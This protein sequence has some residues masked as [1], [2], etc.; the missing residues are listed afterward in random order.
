MEREMADRLWARALPWEL[1]LTGIV[2]GLLV[3][4]AP[5]V[6]LISGLGALGVVVGSLH[7][8]LIGI[9]AA[10]VVGPFRAWLEI[11]APGL[12]PHV[13]QAVLLVAVGAW[14]VQK[15]L[16]TRP[17]G[18][19]KPQRSSAFVSLAPL[20]AFVG[21]GLLSLWDPVDAWTGFLEWVKWAQVLLVAVVVLDRLRATGARGV[22]LALA[23]LGAS[24]GVQALVGI[25]QF[26]L[27]GTGVQ[28][29]AIDDRFYRAYGTFQQPNPYAGMLGLVGALAVGLAAA[30]L[31]DRW[32]EAGPDAPS[33]RR[34]FTRAPFGSAWAVAPAV[35]IVAGLGVSWSRGGWMG[36]GAAG[37]VMIVFLPRR[38][39]WGFLLLGGAVVLITALAATGR[40][41]ASIVERL[42][43]F[44]SYVRFEDVRGAGATDATYAV[45]ERMA[46]WQA[47]L[48]MWRARFWLGVGLGGYE[49][50]YA[51]HRLM[52]WPL[53]LGHAHNSYLNLLAEVGVVGLVAYMIW[54]GGLVVGVIGALRRA[55]GG[56]RALALGLLG[57]WTHLAVHSLV[58]YLLVNNV[59]LHVGVMVA[60]SA[61]VVAVS[62]TDA[63]QSQLAIS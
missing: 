30:T 32:C 38:S 3:A 34:R 47:A 12:A 63:H 36:F 7:E 45:L 21:V 42:T 19:P 51:T 56:P 53:A 60:L 46:H 16:E 10:L 55:D 1:A 49:P 44:L 15:L 52:A 29:F 23:G 31:V 40:L 54:L 22:A 8:P 28:D 37:L 18:F 13:G 33:L 11:R 17:L 58:D 6:V 14:A 39:R 50:A 62:R 59:H 2:L 57:A 41:P 27:A 43:G 24:A 25:W 9:G 4:R 35:L 20:V 61:Y 26:G 5:L 48:G